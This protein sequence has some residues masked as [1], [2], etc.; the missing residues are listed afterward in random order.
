MRMRDSVVH[1]E[2]SFSCMEDYPEIQINK[3]EGNQI[4]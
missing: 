1:I 2:V 4:K 3:L